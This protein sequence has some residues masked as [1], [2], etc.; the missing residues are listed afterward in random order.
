MNSI[1]LDAPRLI[2]WGIDHDLVFPPKCLTAD[3]LD[4]II[5]AVADH[6]GLDPNLI[7]TT[8]QDRPVVRAR[9]LVIHLAAKQ[10]HCTLPSIADQLLVSLTTANN[11]IRT[12]RDELRD[13]NF[14]TARDV[15]ALISQ[16]ST[17]NSK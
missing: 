3:Q 11:A 10:L 16:L 8:S 14:R 17:L 6:L 2:R 5:L 4:P 12:I 13:P 9:R 1:L 15:E 7:R